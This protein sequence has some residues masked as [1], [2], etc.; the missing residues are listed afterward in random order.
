MILTE[1]ELKTKI[2]ICALLFPIFLQTRSPSLGTVLAIHCAHY[3]RHYPLM[4]PFPLTVVP[5][6]TFF[7]LSQQPKSV[8]YSAHLFLSRPLW[9][10]YLPPSF[11]A[12]NLSFLKSSRIWLIYPSLK[13]DS[14]IN[15]N[16]PQSHHCLRVV[17]LISPFHPTTGQFLI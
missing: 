9:T 15:L 17:L 14:L 12:V 16:K 7:H 4:S 10:L 8:S 5:F 3:L 13:A 11:Y 2:V 1:P 6:S